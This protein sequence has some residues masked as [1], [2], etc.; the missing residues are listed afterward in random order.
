ME[1]AFA[2]DGINLLGERGLLKTINQL[3]DNAAVRR[4][5]LPRHIG[6]FI[7]SDE[8]THVRKGGRI[9]KVMTDLQAKELEQRTRELFTE[10]LVSL[11]A[12]QKDMDVFT[13]SREDIEHLVGE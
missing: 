11:G 1:A 8:R 3:I 4:V 13:V 2:M 6:D 12:V 9:I 5:L 7:R 10:C